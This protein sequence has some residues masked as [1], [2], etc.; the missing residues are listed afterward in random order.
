MLSGLEK[1]CQSSIQTITQVAK[2][3]SNQ[4]PLYTS[5]NFEILSLKHHLK[6]GQ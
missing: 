5:A 4:M 3:D 6:H 2:Y 1:E